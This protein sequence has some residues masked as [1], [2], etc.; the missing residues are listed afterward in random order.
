METGN[1][2]AVARGKGMGNNG[3]KK[4]MGLVKEHV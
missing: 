1:R 3:G 4:E 2:L